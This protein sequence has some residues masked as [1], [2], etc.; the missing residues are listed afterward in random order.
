MQD[1]LYISPMKQ[2]LLFALLLLTASAF[3]QH[4]TIEPP[5]KPIEQRQKRFEVG[6]GVQVNALS[7][8]CYF[9]GPMFSFKANSKY[10]RIAGAINV[11]YGFGYTFHSI[12]NSW[13]MYPNYPKTAFYND[14]RYNMMKVNASMIVPFFNRTNKRGFGVSYLLSLSYYNSLGSG[15]YTSFLDKSNPP[16]L[17]PGDYEYVRPSH[18]FSMQN[19]NST[20]FAVETGLSFSYTHHYMQF[21]ID[22]AT[23][24]G[25][26]ATTEMAGNGYVDSNSDSSTN[27][28]GNSPQ[29]SLM[30]NVGMRYCL[31][32][33]WQVKPPK[34]FGKR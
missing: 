32:Q 8:A 11:S 1:C 7:D 23:I 4:D 19:R 12:F 10:G 3:A 21:F 33:P 17:Q 14:I 28:K 22:A 2:F 25:L 13:D 5:R 31:Y 9:T 29:Y 34:R 16:V 26:E 18:K 15:T 20:F 6:G 30:L 27:F 24:V